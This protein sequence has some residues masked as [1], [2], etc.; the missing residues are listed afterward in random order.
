M[1][2]HMEMQRSSRPGLVAQM[3]VLVPTIALSAWL[4]HQGVPLGTRLGLCIGF[5]LMLIAVVAA[6]QRRR[7]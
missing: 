6:W 5:G 1:V 2:Q 7:G 3:A 4:T